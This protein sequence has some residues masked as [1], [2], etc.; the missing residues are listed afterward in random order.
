M[1]LGVCVCAVM[2]LAGAAFAGTTTAVRT[3]DQEPDGSPAVGIWGDYPTDSAP[4]WGAGCFEA[5]GT[6]KSNYYTSPQELFGRDD[7]KIS[8]LE[9][10]AY[11]TKKDTTHAVSA[12]D[13]Y[14]L[15]YTE[16]YSG[17]PGSSWYGNR[18]HTEPYFSESINDPANTW[19]QWQTDAGKDNRLRFY[20]GSSGYLGSYTDGF[21]ED[22]TSDPD[23]KDQEILYIAVSTGSGWASGFTGRVD[24]LVIELANGDVGRLNLEPVPEPISMIFFGT[25]VVGVFGYVARRKMRSRD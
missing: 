3:V 12:P 21:L 20:D 10:I 23:L 13:W 22:L 17:S 5:N 7:V 24:G 18:I 16:P 19:N 8:E 9:S 14:L 6:S 15:I 4:G 2:L 1:I 25:G 11:W